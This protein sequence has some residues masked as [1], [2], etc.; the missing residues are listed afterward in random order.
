MSDPIFVQRMKD[1][2]L[3]NCEAC[4]DWGNDVVPC[5]KDDVPVGNLCSMCQRE[6][7]SHPE[8]EL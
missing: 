5:V 3:K 8:S 2:G 4:G 7:K 1:A 6:T